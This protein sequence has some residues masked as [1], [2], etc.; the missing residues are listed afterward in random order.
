M[1]KQ[2]KLLNCKALYRV[3]MLKGAPQ[4]MRENMMRN[5]TIRSFSLLTL[6]VLLLTGVLQASQKKTIEPGTSIT[7]I[8]I[9]YRLDPRLARGMY[10]GDRWGSPVI[11]ST[12]GSRKELSIEAQAEGLNAKQKTFHIIPKW[13][14]SDTEMVTVSSVKGK[15]HQVK[16]LVRRTGKCILKVSALG[17]TKTLIIKAVFKHN[18][19]HVDI[20][21]NATEPK[22][23]V[24]VPGKS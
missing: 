1:S 10:M 20:V 14:P 5:L 15:D 6:I 4:E 24:T 11:F 3:A 19:M 21:N 7:D 22:I 18:A 13:S 23:H 17:L 9:S 8:K 16:I 2:G 12:A